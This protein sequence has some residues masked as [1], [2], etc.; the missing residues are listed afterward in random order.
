[1]FAYALTCYWA[2]HFIDNV[3]WTAKGKN[4]L[5]KNRKG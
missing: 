4:T 1:M 5:I 2:V 3:N